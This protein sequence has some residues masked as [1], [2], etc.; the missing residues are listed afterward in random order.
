LQDLREPGHNGKGDAEVMRYLSFY[1][2]RNRWSWRLSAYQQAHRIP[3]TRKSVSY[4][5]E[6]VD[7]GITRL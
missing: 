7:A 4:Q 5:L 6:R 3:R 1:L 2:N